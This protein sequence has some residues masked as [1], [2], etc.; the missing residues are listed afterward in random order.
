MS[1]TIRFFVPGIPRPGG[2]KKPCAV[3]NREGKPVTKDGRLILSV[4]EGNEKTREWRTDVRAAAQEVFKDA[5][6][7]GPV[8]LRA[9]FFFPRPKSHYGTGR[10]ANTLKASAPKQI[11]KAPDCTKL[12]R[13]LEDALS[14]VVWLDDS[15]V[16][17]QLAQKSW[18]ERPGA[19][20]EIEP[21]GDEERLI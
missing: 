18:G 19:V 5:P 13:S 16:V 21:L 10:N 7:A 20:V 1:R 8:V 9:H 12:M 17:L 6:L 11:T 4:R 15:Q 3:Y 2:N 14:G